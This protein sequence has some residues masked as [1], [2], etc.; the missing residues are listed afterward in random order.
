MSPLVWLG[1]ALLILAN[2]L[3]VAG[4]FGA[5]GVR[6]SKVRRL[7]DDGSVLARR[8]LPY[9]DDAVQLD[10]YI[11]ASQIGITISSLA[12]GAF[13]QATVTVSLAPMVAS[14]F[15]LDP[16][17]AFSITT[18]V[19]L[20]ILTGAQLIIGELVPK[21]LA[22]QFP[23]EAALATVMP[24]QWSLA[25]F[26]PL[27]FVLNGAATLM[28]RLVRVEI[29]GHRHLHSPEEIE[30]MIAESRDGGLLEPDEQQRLRRALRLGARPAGD[31]M[32][33]RARM[34]TLPRSATWDDVVRTV[35]ASP[36]S[37][38]PVLDPDTDRVVGML[39]VK[40]LVDRY[41]AEGPQ[42]LDR[43]IRPLVTLRQDLPADQV[44]AQL[45]E[46]RMHLAAL[47]DAA[48]Q[49]TGLITIQDLLGELLGHGGTE[50]VRA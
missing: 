34:T 24:L 15:A 1:L 14:A 26:R 16:V 39:R 43:M 20:T 22:L 5:V 19:V 32:V 7:A 45:R 35:S 10:R 23:T 37:R 48:G 13:A 44:L 21:A 47:V 25:V 11:G 50:P 18:V 4:E 29:E 9:V 30:L 49:V 42:P 40:D 28:L 41:V 6:R 31:L 27:L 46:H 2:S 12:L 17:V 38:I 36:F 3:Y 33:P 8:L